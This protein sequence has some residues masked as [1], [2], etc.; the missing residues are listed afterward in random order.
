MMAFLSLFLA[1]APA[2]EPPRV[3]AVSPDWGWQG[4]D[5]TVTLTGAAF[6]PDVQVST[7]EADAGEVDVNFQVWIET[8]TPTALTFV[9]LLDYG[10]LAAQVPA[11]LDVGLYGLRVVTPSGLSDTLPDAFSVTE[12][13]A[14]HLTIGLSDAAF[15]VNESGTL[16]LRL[17]DPDAEPVA[18]AMQVEVR[19]TSALGASGIRF[20]EGLGDQV[21]T[22]D[23]VG[24]R[25]TLGPD[26]AAMVLVSSTV[27]DDVLFTLSPVDDAVVDS[28]S[29]LVSWEPGALTNVEIV[30]PSANFRATAGEAFDVDLLLYDRDGNQLGPQAAEV[31]LFDA[32]GSYSQAIDLSAPGPWTVEL[33]TACPENTLHTVGLY[34]EDGVSAPFPVLPG[35]QAG[36]AVTAYPDPV[37]AGSGLLLVQVDGVDFY[38]NIVSGAVGSVTLTDSVGGLDPSRGVGTQSCGSFDDGRLFCTASPR[39]AASGVVIHARDSLG[40][41]GASDPLEVLPDAP[42][43]VTV[44]VSSLTLVAGDPFGISVGV[45]DAW[46][47]AIEVDAGGSEPVVLT[48]DTGS[49]ACSYDGPVGSEVAYVCT[50]TRT[51]PGDVIGARVL[52]LDAFA[53]GAYPIVNG[54]LGEIEVELFSATYTAGVQFT[55]H[56]TGFDAYGNLYTV[57]TS[58]AGFDLTDTTGTISPVLAYFDADGDTSISASI[59]TAADDVRILASQAGILR[60]ESPD[61]NVLPGQMAGFEVVVDPWLDVSAD[62]TVVISPVDAYGNVVPT[63]DQL[64]EVT[65]SLGLC[66]PA[67]TDTFTVGRVAL[68]LV[69]PNVGL[70]DTLLV[71]DSSGFAGMSDPFDVLDLGCADGPTADLLLDRDTEVVACLTSGEASVV[72]DATGSVAGASALA[73][74]HL[75]DDDGRAYRGSSATRSFDYTSTGTRRITAVAVD[76]RACASEA[77]GLVYIGEDDGTPSGPLSLSSRAVSVATGGST[78]VDVAAYDCAGDVAIAGTLLVRSD[79]GV[80]AG[81]ATGTGLE[82]VLDAS[83]AAAVDW[84]FPTGY[85]GEAT[86]YFGTESGSAL[87]ALAQTVSGDSVRPQVVSVSPTG[88]A[89]GGV[90]SIEVV[91]NE[92]MR[93]LSVVADAFAL[94]GPD[95]DQGFAVTLSDDG[96]VATVT[97][98]LELDAGA[99]EW[100]LTLSDALRDLAGN[101]LSGDFSGG[102][103]AFVTAFGDVAEDLPVVSSCAVDT[104]RFR[105]DGDPGSVRDAETFSVTPTTSSAPYRWWMMVERQDGGRV[106]SLRVDGSETAVTWDGRGDDGRVVDSNTY[107]ARLYAEDAYGNSREMCASGVAVEQH[108]EMR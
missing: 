70:Q 2:P 25:G 21:P 30:L 105:P 50:V 93:S 96:T 29:V 35:P 56:F 90:E 86:I 5:T 36:L 42:A 64:V 47:N 87:G 61:F 98:D 101:R 72:A 32:C 23:G 99:G 83:G 4:E 48:D 80:P 89:E 95:G 77:S 20:G 102:A 79:L 62:A 55:V 24:I 60:G 67:E 63:Y 51:D 69:C 108:V 46:G 33:V 75:V 17:E 10:T 13:R 49:L 73:V 66:E 43:E 1:C 34:M 85:S 45:Y 12:T 53:P 7:Y 107:V 100:T 82:V 37:V 57:P 52:G 38:G 19:A 74:Y 40:F 84:S 76:T 9:Q 14:D 71:T 26:G 78:T 103:A 22:E 11:G 68:G 16:E 104:G 106:R 81:T 15:D 31:I 65:S 88:A 58:G 44:S 94:T 92:A 27:P 91:F 3:D 6:F 28:D 97:P 39:V 59:T 8:P 41:V 18:Q 54:A